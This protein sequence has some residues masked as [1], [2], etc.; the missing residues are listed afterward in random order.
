ML[1]LYTQHTSDCIRYRNYKHPPRAKAWLMKLAPVRT[2]ALRPFYFWIVL[3][4]VLVPTAGAR[5][6]LD[7]ELADL[8]SGWG[9][10]WGSSWEAGLVGNDFSQLY[11]WISLCLDFL[12]FF[13]VFSCLVFSHKLSPSS[14]RLLLTG[15]GWEGKWRHRWRKQWRG[16]F[17]FRSS[18]DW[19]ARSLAGDLLG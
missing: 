10:A 6:F 16:V 12:F 1:L 11:F 17:T 18:W 7:R 9:Y 15:P 4:E 14:Q 5:D 19:S 3:L 8:P 2:R 13:L